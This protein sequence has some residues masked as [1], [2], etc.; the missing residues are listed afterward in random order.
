MK[1]LHFTR[2]GRMHVACLGNSTFIVHETTTGAITAKV[3]RRTRARPI[4]S[5]F[6][7]TIAEAIDWLSR[8]SKE[9][10]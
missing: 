7:R 8:W 4:A 9:R 1:Q 6:C 3:F 5:K 10:S 2:T